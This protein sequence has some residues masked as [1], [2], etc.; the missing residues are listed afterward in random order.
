VRTVFA[1]HLSLLTLHF[2]P[3]TDPPMVPETSDSPPASLVP[4]PH[5]RRN[6]FALLGDYVG[7]GLGATFAS[8]TTVIPDFIGRL[9]AST[10]VV[11]LFLTIADGAW[12]L[13]QLFFANLLVDKRRKKP[14]V[15]WS[16]LLGR[17]TWLLYAAALC[18]G[19]ANSPGTAILLLFL[20][21]LVFAGS[22][23]LASVAWFDILAK[24]IPEERRGRL[25]GLAQL[26]QGVLAIGVGAIVAALLSDRGPPF[27]LNYAA[28]FGL[29]GVFYLSSLAS[30]LP[31]VE[32]DEAVAEARPSWRE[33]LPQLLRLLREDRTFRRL[34]IV[35]LLAGFDMLAWSFYVLFATRELGLPPATVGLFV[36]VQTAGSIVGS[37]LLGLISE[38]VGSHRVIQVGT[39]V[40][41]TAPLVGLGL[42]LSKVGGGAPLALVLSSYI[43][44]ALGIV[45]SSFMLGHLN[46][47][48]DVAPSAQRPIYVGLLNTLGGAIVVLP[49]LG[50]LLLEYTS[51][52]VLFGLTAAVV[53]VGHL[54]SWRLPSMRGVS[55][56]G[57]GQTYGDAGPSGEENSASGA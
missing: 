14:Y 20:L 29:A 53:L 24:T 21:Y 19:L 46:Y 3:N 2:S 39:A 17:P 16:G 15:I 5:Y 18:L 52:S 36:A 11:G 30:F 28:I 42:A 33:Y 32:P 50:G 48:L 55:R 23:S 40:S 8:V 57:H 22:D 9:T 56:T 41:V 25:V 1:L 27:P 38:R 35:R 31:V 7:F 45:S 43:F 12:L 6:F 54:F 13:P 51:Y 26:V 49:P 10:V 34:V 37:V 4:P 47:V 44:L